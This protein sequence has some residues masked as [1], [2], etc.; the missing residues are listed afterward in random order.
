LQIPPN[1]GFSRSQY[2]SK[3]NIT[4]T[5]HFGDKVTTGR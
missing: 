4:K 3:A 5:V 1:P 2:F